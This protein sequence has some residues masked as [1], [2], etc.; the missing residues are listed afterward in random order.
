VRDFLQEQRQSLATGSSAS[1]AS[2]PV[3]LTREE[4]QQLQNELNSVQREFNSL[5]DRARELESRLELQPDRSELPQRLETIESALRKATTLVGNTA[6]SL[7]D[8][9]SSSNRVQVTLP[10][11][12]LFTPQ[13]TLSPDASLILDTVL[14]DLQRYPGSTLR[15]AVH[16]DATD[17]PQDSRERSFRQAGILKDYLKEKLGDNYRWVPVGYGQSRPLAP[18]DTESNR[19]RNRR[20]EISI[21]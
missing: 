20:V 4:K 19:Q 12:I 7:E 15:V 11:D 1:D 5:R 9:S 6:I 17:N 13:N 2:P 8:S 14:A 3:S 18:N 16:T 21:D 10:V